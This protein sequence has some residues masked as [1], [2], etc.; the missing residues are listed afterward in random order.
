MKIAQVRQRFAATAALYRCPLCGQPLTL[1]ETS[2]FCPQRH[3]FDLA[4]KGYVNFAP[5]QKP[6]QYDRELFRSRQR[7]LE[8][9]FYE[10]LCQTLVELIQRHGA[11]GGRLLDAGCGEGY[12]AAELARRLPQYQV[13]A[14]DL[15]K[16][17]LQLAGRRCPPVAWLVGNL[18]HLP[19]ADH[20]LDGVLN[21]LSPANYGEFFRVLR[22][23]G[24]LLKV[25]PGP[26]YLR[27]IRELLGRS[28]P[29]SNEPV[30]A[31]LSRQVEVVERRRLRQ[32]WPLMPD[33]AADWL[34]MT[35]LSFHAD[36]NAVPPERL[37]Q[38]TLD[39][40]V[41]VGRGRRPLP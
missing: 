8:G 12:Y 30:L 38:V 9:G 4:A 11:A 10:P 24:W 28:D 31:V 15:S 23:Q 40:E 29:Y 34:R 3:C 36:V 20:C 18:A 13:L 32:C 2:F 22:P 5:Q 33:Q 6:P 21:L 16:E 19:L 35:P 37:T 14:V 17:A 1:T 26:H 7:I 41:I 25:I 39:L 27:E